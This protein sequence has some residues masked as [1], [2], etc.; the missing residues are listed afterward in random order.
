MTLYGTLAL[1]CFLGF[2]LCVILGQ[3]L[4]FK[5]VDAINQCRGREEQLEL[6]GFF[7]NPMSIWK[8]LCLYRSYY[9]KGKFVRSY[10]L[11]VAVGNLCFLMTIFFVVLIVR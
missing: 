11:T 10:W 6:F 2:L 8:M 4:N 3:I 7:P 1:A 5:I 9:P